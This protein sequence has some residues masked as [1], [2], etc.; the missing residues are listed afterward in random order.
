ML[1]SRT[2][3]EAR[4]TYLVLLIEGSHNTRYYGLKAHY[5][6]SPV[7]GSGRTFLIQGNVLIEESALNYLSTYLM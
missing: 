6:T 1:M 7:I 5:Y 4:L 3:I 2:P